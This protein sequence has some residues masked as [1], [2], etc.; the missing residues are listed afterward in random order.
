MEELQKTRLK[1]QSLL[2]NLSNKESI[3]AD[4][5]VELHILT[6]ENQRLKA[7]LEKLNESAEK[8]VQN[9]DS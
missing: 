5:R 1:V 9:P 2:N 8:A 4:L 6:V 3:E 7:E